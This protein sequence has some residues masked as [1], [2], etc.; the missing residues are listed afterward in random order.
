MRGHFPAV[1]MPCILVLV[2]LASRC[3]IT[4][5]TP[6]WALDERARVMWAKHSNNRFS[7][8][9]INLVLFCADDGTVLN[10]IASPQRN[11][12]YRKKI[13]GYNGWSNFIIMTTR[14]KRSVSSTTTLNGA[15]RWRRPLV[16]RMRGSKDISS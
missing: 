5:K 10:R 16:N 12:K 4:I 7:N 2:A 9:W 13:L 3:S 11:T 8:W 1:V 6:G 15:I 14:M